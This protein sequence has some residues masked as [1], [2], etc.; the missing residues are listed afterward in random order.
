MPYF[1]QERKKGEIGVIFQH[2][3]STFCGLGKQRMFVFFFFKK[4]KIKKKKNLSYF[5]VILPAADVKQVIKKCWPRRGFQIN[6][7]RIRRVL[8]YWAKLQG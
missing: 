8:L 4:K 1:Q 6:E 2:V 5:D 7:V 3:T